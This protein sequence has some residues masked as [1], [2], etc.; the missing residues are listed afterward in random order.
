M[1]K[2]AYEYLG[3]NRAIRRSDLLSIQ[4]VIRGPKPK[5]KANG[6]LRNGGNSLHKRIEP[7]RHIHRIMAMA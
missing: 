3:P 1:S 4:E 6:K 7:M 5:G 2:A